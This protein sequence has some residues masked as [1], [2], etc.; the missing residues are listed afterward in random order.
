MYTPA[1]PNIGQLITPLYFHSS[2]SRRVDV[3]LNQQRVSPLKCTRGTRDSIILRR[4]THD[5]TSAAPVLY[6]LHGGVNEEYRWVK[7]R[8]YT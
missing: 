6:I 2:R 5:T 8:K 1:R 4:E 7:H 3:A